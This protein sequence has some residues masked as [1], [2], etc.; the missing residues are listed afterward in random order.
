MDSSAFQR[1]FPEGTVVNF[2]LKNTCRALPAV[3]TPPGL[4]RAAGAPAGSLT[5]RELLQAPTALAEDGP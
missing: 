2:A 3:R 5:R 1:P 4:G